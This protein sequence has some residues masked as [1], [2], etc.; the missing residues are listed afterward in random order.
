[1]AGWLN[2]PVF[3][4]HLAPLGP[5]ATLE[6]WLD[7]VVGGAARAIGMGELPHLDEA[8]EYML[9]GLATAVAIGSVLGA[10]WWFRRQTIVP[11]KEDATPWTGFSK[12]LFN[13]YYVD[14]IYDAVI[15]RPLHWFSQS[16]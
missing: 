9:V 8:T 5:T 6:H 15:V 12:V 10:M 4:T 3:L 1:T 13:K 7:P 14:E 11:V 2:L 16:V